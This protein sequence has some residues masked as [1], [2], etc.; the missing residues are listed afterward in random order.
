MPLATAPNASIPAGGQTEDAN[1]QTLYASRPLKNGADLLAWAREAGFKKTLT[2]DEM[3]VTLAFS[4]APLAWPDASTD[5]VTV[6]DASDSLNGTR[7]IEQLGDEGA[8]VL[9]FE[10][11]ELTRRWH[12]L[13]AAGADWQYPNFKPHVTFTMDAGNIDLSKVA[14]YAG[15]LEFGPEVF[16]E[17]EDGAADWA[18]KARASM[19]G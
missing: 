2:P 12:A 15:E 1:P 16:K 5:D 18:E 11:P 14:P 19:V 17:I 4:K 9:R 7:S 8:I 3:H 13:C 6:P 10:S